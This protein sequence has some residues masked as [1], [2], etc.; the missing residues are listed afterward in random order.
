MKT[1][2]FYIEYLLSEKAK[3]KNIDTGRERSLINMM[4]RTESLKSRQE[5]NI[6]VM[7]TIHMKGLTRL[8][9]KAAKLSTLT[10]SMVN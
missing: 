10:I 8:R 4:N 2:G 1:E 6:P 5:V 7:C 9:R 3:C